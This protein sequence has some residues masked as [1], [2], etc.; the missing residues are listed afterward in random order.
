MFE[1]EKKKASFNIRDL[2]EVIY[3]GKEGFEEYL[4]QQTIVD[5]DPVL[6][7]DPSFHHQ[8]RHHMMEIMS[9]KLLRLH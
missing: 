7:F 1:A 6:K 8:S 4:K 3:G 2:S 9:K 5:K